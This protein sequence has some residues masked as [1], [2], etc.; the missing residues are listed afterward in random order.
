M[1]GLNICSFHDPD[2]GDLSAR[3]HSVT[4]KGPS[5]DIHIC[6]THMKNSDN[7]LQITVGVKTARTELDQKVS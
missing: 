6:S 3:N 1:P 5:G 4:Y 2:G 7:I